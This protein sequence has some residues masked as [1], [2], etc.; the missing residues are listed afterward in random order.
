[1]GDAI[2][3]LRLPFRRIYVLPHKYIN[4]YVWKPDDQVSSNTDLQE[5]LLGRWTYVG[6]LTPDDPG[7]FRRLS[8]RLSR[9]L[10]S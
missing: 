1:M 2:Y 10:T 8:T 7:E 9:V 6:S 4:E 3:L 5:R